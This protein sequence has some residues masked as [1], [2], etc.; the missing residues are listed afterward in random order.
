M[1]L[2]CCCLPALTLARH[3]SPS[4]HV[5]NTPASPAG[6]SIWATDVPGWITAVATAGLLIGA[7]ITAIYAA[8]A[9]NAQFRAERPEPAPAPRLA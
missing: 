2:S 4:P 3:V 8:K 1:P 5:S 6:G 9:F 7:I